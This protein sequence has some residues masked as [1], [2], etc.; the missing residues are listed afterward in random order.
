MTPGMAKL[1]MSA[2]ALSI[3]VALVLAAGCAGTTTAMVSTS[4][5]VPRPLPPGGSFGTP[6][7]LAGVP[8]LGMTAPFPDGLQVS[9]TSAGNCGA[10]GGY[11]AKAAGK[12]TQAQREAFVVT[13]TNGQWGKPEPVPGLAALNTWGQV[14]NLRIMCSASGFCEAGGNYTTK[15]TADSG[16]DHA[17]VV[18][19]SKGGWG[20]ARTFDPSGLSASANG[21]SD[22]DSLTCPAPGNCVAG[23]DYGSP[24]GSVPFI[25]AQRHGVWG[26]PQ[27]IPGLAALLG[28]TRNVVSSPRAI[29]CT[30]A[31]DCTVIGDYPD[32]AHY[33]MDAFIATEKHGGW[34]K[35]APL[36]GLA[37]LQS[38]AGNRYTDVDALAC[39]PAGRNC[40]AA[41]VFTNPQGHTVPF[42]LTKVHGRWGTVTPLPG[43]S[44]LNLNN[45]N[46]GGV[47]LSCPTQASCTIATNAWTAPDGSPLAFGNSQVYLDSEVNGAW[48]TPK[49]LGG[50]PADLGGGGS[51]TVLAC[52]APASCTIGGYYGNNHSPG[53]AFLAKEISGT[54]SGPIKVVLPAS[55]NSVTQIGSLS[56]AADGYCTATAFA[57]FQPAGAVHPTAYVIAEGAPTKVPFRLVKAE[58]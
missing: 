37:A 17:F 58:V 54:W 31:A 48:G 41:G 52:G 44:S 36:P 15:L 14:S 38:T 10:I 26:K 45:G 7:P 13:E 29:S 22:L 40:T 53:V 23:A 43:T 57:Q 5:A 19:E 24:Q 49:H 11:T 56:C 9:C 25:V 55:A 28:S 34:T 47:L 30:D 12:G 20:N 6:Q 33:R 50:V 18:T 27:L 39:D 2:K 21:A 35:A 1:T 51:V 8:G 4:A 16:N 32:N 3:A 46:G 42:V